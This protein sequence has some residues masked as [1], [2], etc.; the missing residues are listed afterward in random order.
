[1]IKT[2]LNYR[3]I[4]RCFSIKHAQKGT[5]LTKTLRLTLATSDFFRPLGSTE[6]KTKVYLGSYQRNAQ[7]CVGQDHKKP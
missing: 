7:G 2:Y 6:V 1:M 4:Y 5:E 3:T